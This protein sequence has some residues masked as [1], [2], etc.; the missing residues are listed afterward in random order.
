MQMMHAAIGTARQCRRCVPIRSS[1][2]T[3]TEEPVSSAVPGG[4]ATSDD[5]R[6]GGVVSCNLRFSAGGD[7]ALRLE[8]R[9]IEHQ[10]WLRR[11]IAAIA[12]VGR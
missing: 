11:C 8:A 9:A 6:S 10:Q 12:A 2:M 3:T 7:E 5:D 4:A 1:R